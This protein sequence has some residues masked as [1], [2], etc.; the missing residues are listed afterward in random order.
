MP[1]STRNRP[2]ISVRQRSNPSFA[3]G[4]VPM[5]SQKQ[6]SP[7]SRQFTATRNALRRRATYRD[8]LKGAPVK[9]RSWILMA[10]RSQ[11][12]TPMKAMGGSSTGGRY[13]SMLLPWRLSWMRGSR[14]GKRCRFQD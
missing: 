7:G 14:G 2:F 8:S 5:E 6:R 12:L 4:P 3:S 13:H 1:A 11:G 10:A 9:T